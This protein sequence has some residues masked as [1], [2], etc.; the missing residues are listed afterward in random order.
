VI[1]I[2]LI[3]CQIID[4]KSIKDSGIWYF[5]EKITILAGKNDAGKTAILEALE[6]FNVNKSIKVEAKPIHNDS[7]IPII[8]IWFMFEK[9]DYSLFPKETIDA[10]TQK[11]TEIQIEK[12]FPNVYNIYNSFYDSFEIKKNSGFSKEKF[13]DLIDLMDKFIPDIN[14]NEEVFKEEV[15]KNPFDLE[16]L[17]KVIKETNPSEEK[18]KIIQAFNKRLSE[19]LKIEKSFET[20]IKTKMIPNFILFSTFED[21]LPT[22]KPIS[23][24]VSDPLLKDLALIS[25]LDFSKIQPDS[26]PRLKFKHREEVNLKFS[27]DYKMFWTQ[28]NSQLVFEWDSTNIYFY[29]MENGE[30]YKP[31]IRSKGKQ[32]YLTF[33]IRVTARALE[34]ANNI[35]LI[36]EP[37]LFLHAKAQRDVLRKLEECCQKNQI[38]FTTHSPYLI[39]SNKLNRV[40]LVIKEII[41]GTVIKKITAKADKETLTP[42]LTAI[43]EDLSGGIRTDKNN[44]IVLEGYSD[45]LWLIAWKKLIVTNDE[46]NFIPSVGASKTIYVGAILFGWGLNP[47]FLLDND[48]A[49]NLAKRKLIRHLGILEENIIQIPEEREGTIED[50]FSQNDFNKYANYKEGSNSKTLLAKI[51]LQKIE[52]GELTIKDLE[53]ETIEGFKKI[54]EKLKDRINTQNE[55]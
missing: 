30:L 34:E 22:N 5:D 35:I 41:E 2:R 11:E 6:D 39:L 43:G 8:K 29:I 16:K 21:Q 37:G 38:I 13:Q 32:W 47:I 7:L 45:Y 17:L 55:I 18:N 4:Y 49:G 15:F 52:N 40:R 19:F 36:D 10:L 51:F 42:I 3:K 50:I 1:L 31:E 14:F 46:L 20:I 48:R 9:K 24:A 54:F 33:Y 23:A 53:K 12:R 28:D 44:S 25:G 27:E 26:D